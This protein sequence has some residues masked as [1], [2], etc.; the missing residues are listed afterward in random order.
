MGIFAF[1]FLIFLALNHVTLIFGAEII[2]SLGWNTLFQVTFVDGFARYPGDY[3]FIHCKTRNPVELNNNWCRATDTE[4][5]R[6]LSED[7]QFLSGGQ[8]IRECLLKN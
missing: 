1:P 4:A 2:M 7:G 6:F 8:P 3:H 5:A